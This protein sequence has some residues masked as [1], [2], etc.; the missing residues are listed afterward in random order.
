MYRYYFVCVF[1]KHLRS[2][3]TR[4]CHRGRDPVA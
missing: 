2:L 3:P 4:S 1:N